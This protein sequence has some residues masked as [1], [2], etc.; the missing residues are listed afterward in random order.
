QVFQLIRGGRDA[1]LRGRSTRGI[2]RRLADKQ[3]L[4]ADVVQ[5]LLD[6]YSFLRNLEHRL[7]YL[8]DA[9]THALPVNDSDRLVVAQMMGMAD[10]ATLLA[11]LD[12][13]RTFVAAQFD[14]IFSDKT[15]DG[16][17]RTDDRPNGSD[18]SIE[19]N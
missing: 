3:L 5:Q 14:A 8:E 19:R 17:G 12:T 10:V 6:S 1:S 15:V 9:Q 11:A 18:H 7:Q 2:L 16:S 4:D 13:H